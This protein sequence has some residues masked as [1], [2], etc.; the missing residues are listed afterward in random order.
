MVSI[1]KNKSISRWAT[2]TTYDVDQLARDTGFWLARDFANCDASFKAHPLYKRDKWTSV[3]RAPFKKLAYWGTFRQVARFKMHYQLEM[4]FKKYTFASDDVSPQ[5]RE[6]NTVNKYMEH[7]RELLSPREPYKTLTFRVLQGARKVIKELLGDPDE[8]EI[9]QFQRF[10]QKSSIGSPLARSFVDLKLCE[11]APFSSNWLSAQAFR[12]YLK[13]DT[14]LAEHMTNAGLY[15]GVNIFPVLEESLTYI[16]VPKTYKID[17]G[18]TPLTLLAL[19]RSFG[20]GGVIEDRLKGVGINIKRQQVRHRRWICKYSRVRDHVTADLSSASDC[21]TIELLSW[22]FPRKW[23]IL[24]KEIISRKTEVPGHGLVTVASVMPMGNGATFPIETLVFYALLRSLGNLTGI[25]GNYSV[26]GDD[27]I[28]PTPLH[29]YVAVVFAD[30]SLKLNSDK[31]FTDA[32]FRESCGSDYYHGIDVRPAFFP[33]SARFVT[34]VQYA[35]LCYKMIN[36]L[37]YRWDATAVRLTVEYLL[38]E[39]RF[40]GL[41]IYRVPRDYSADSGIQTDD[42]R[43]FELVFPSDGYSRINRVPNYGCVVN[44][45]KAF[46]P[47]TG[48]RHVVAILPYYWQT[49]KHNASRE[50]RRPDFW[51]TKVA[52]KN[53]TALDSAAELTWT[54][55]RWTR[56]FRR[57]DGSRMTRVSTKYKGWSSTREAHTKV[58]V[59]S[60]FDWSSRSVPK[61]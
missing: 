35:Q 29:K 34:R 22:L 51:E 33:V 2:P 39:I 45:F 58:G 12:E 27:L 19:F 44:S 28:Y 8:E 31:T 24:I 36:K 11:R 13:S 18:I 60:V 20:I 50:L 42:P 16:P 26:Y 5:Q 15:D 32:H 37:L 52:L 3:H 25:S 6:D 7:Q 46:K 54:T 47:S 1:K 38:D 59:V 21:L 49:L 43:V 61:R 40:T 4:L 10:G 55:H 57:K 9:R 23:L 17:R 41:E 56:T 53:L 14:L 48:R 30:L